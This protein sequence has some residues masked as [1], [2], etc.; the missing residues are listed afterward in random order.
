[1]NATGIADQESISEDN[2]LVVLTNA[3]QA[4]TAPQLSIQ[5]QPTNAIVSWSSVA[6][7]F[8]LQKNNSISKGGWISLTNNTFNKGSSKVLTQ[9]LKTG[10]NQTFFRAI[11]R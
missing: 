3:Y 11:Q 9:T 1:M 10:T 7:A 6:P 2:N 8:V 5:I 4:L